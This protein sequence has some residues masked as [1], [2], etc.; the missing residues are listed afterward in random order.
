MPP[1]E[2]PLAPPDLI[3]MLFVFVFPPLL[4]LLL[5]VFVFVFVLVFELELLFPVAVAPALDPATQI[6]LHPHR[7]KSG[8]EDLH[9]ADVAVALAV[10]GTATLQY[11]VYTDRALVKSG[12]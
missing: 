12:A 10:V 4:L 8:P 2:R 6:S 9:P 5:F 1:D 11:S 7:L 3:V